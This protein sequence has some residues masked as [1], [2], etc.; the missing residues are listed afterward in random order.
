V[1]RKPFGVLWRYRDGR[2][3]ERWD[4]TAAGAQDLVARC[5]PWNG[6]EG[7]ASAGFDPCPVAVLTPGEER[8]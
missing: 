6:K 5:K 2:E 1:S 8:E 3:F 4:Y 7:S